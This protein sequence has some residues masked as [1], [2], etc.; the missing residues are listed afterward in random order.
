VGGGQPAQALLDGGYSLHPSALGDRL[1]DRTRDVAYVKPRLRG[2]LHAASFGAAL[3]VGVILISTVRG[4]VHTADATVYALAVVALFGTSAVYHLG[5]WVGAASMRM[6]R[7]DQMMIVVLIAG[8]A[9]V[10]IQVSVPAGWNT[11]GVALLWTLAGAAI[12]FRLSRTVAPERVVGAIYIGL[13]WL[14]G[15]AIPFVWGHNGIAPALLFIAGGV[16]YSVGAIG[17]HRR[18]PDPIPTV[19]GYHEVFHIYVTAAAACHYV[20]IACFLL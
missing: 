14:S 6:Q 8:S 7:L 16:L 19:F 15:V 1:Y 12:A 4:A 18:R 5:H 9:T 20:A 13:G 10:P 2:W 3:V 11:A 17:Y